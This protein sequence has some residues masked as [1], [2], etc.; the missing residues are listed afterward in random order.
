MRQAD[1]EVFKAIQPSVEFELAEVM[2]VA[3]GWVF[4]RA[5]NSAVSG[6]SCPMR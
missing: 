4:A 6:L 3:P 1:E 5:N 2:E